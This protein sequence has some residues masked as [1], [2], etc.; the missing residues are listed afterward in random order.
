MKAGADRGAQ[1]SLLG[2]PKL[3]DRNRYGCRQKIFFDH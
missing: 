1:E 3:E 2:L